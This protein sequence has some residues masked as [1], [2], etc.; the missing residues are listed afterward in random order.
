LEF[1]RGIDQIGTIE[2][3]VV[4]T[5][6]FDGVHVGHR[7]ILDRLKSTAARVNGQSVVVTFHP[8]PRLV[9]FPDDNDLRLIDTLEERVELLRGT[10][11][12]HLVVLEFTREFSRITSLDYV[13]NILVSKLGTMKLVMGYDHHFG[14][15]REG[16]LA[17][18]R[19]FGPVYGFEVEEIPA[20]DVD[21][22]AVSSTKIRKALAEG[23]VATAARY[24]GRPFAL[25][26]SVVQGDR[27]G[28]TLGFPTANIGHIDP[29]KIMPRDGVYKVE[30]DVAQGTFRGMLNI[31]VRPTLGSVEHRVEVHLFHFDADLYGQPIAV[32]LLNRI[33]DERQ[34]SDLDQLRTQ[35]MADAE[36]A[37]A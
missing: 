22:V 1:H 5:G 32:R 6:T 7:T 30:A 25:A 26:G 24:L 34:F 19:E 2:R 4:T 9:L 17:H 8:H 23:D 13:R 33:R 36:V 16:T 20:H 35:L 15:N 21:A 10:G 11:I 3:S 27:L 28:R 12:D 37:S 29:L 14:R 31:G 18:L